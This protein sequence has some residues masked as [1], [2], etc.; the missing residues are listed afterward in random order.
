M[1][2][3]IWGRA[4]HSISIHYHSSKW[5]INNSALFR[6][7]G[8]QVV[9]HLDAL[10][11]PDGSPEGKERRLEWMISFACV[12]K[13]KPK[14]QFLPGGK[15]TDS[16]KCIKETD[17][18]T[19]NV[20]QKAPISI[21]PP[22]FSVALCACCTRWCSTKQLAGVFD[23]SRFR[24]AWSQIII[25]CFFDPLDPF[26]CGACPHW[27]VCKFQ[28]FWR[29]SVPPKVLCCAYRELLPWNF[30]HIRF[31]PVVRLGTWM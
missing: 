9:I 21:T 7:G 23:T 20:I 29:R 3:P 22:T 10:Y 6:K 26:L 1:C 31:H 12:G 11:V 28:S 30:W 27:A 5:F 24:G 8:K 18:N 16:W 25:S 2:I 4:K 14:L 19:T 15:G 17:Y 13:K